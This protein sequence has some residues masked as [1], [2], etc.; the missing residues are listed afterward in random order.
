M[1]DLREICWMAVEPRY[2]ID[3]D[4]LLQSL[5]ARDASD[6]VAVS[7]VERPPAGAGRR[8]N[9][10]GGVVWRAEDYDAF[11]A[12]SQESYRRIRAFADVLAKSP[13]HEFTTTAVC[14]EAKLTPTQLRAALGKFTIWMHATTETDQWP[15]AWAYGED[16]DPTNPAEFHYSMSDEQ[17]NA[18]NKAKQRSRPS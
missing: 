8:R 3:V 11:M 6:P 16:V 2:A 1:N 9:N 12:A 7:A 13:T 5:R 10:G 14:G 4:G 17:A 15:F 18:W